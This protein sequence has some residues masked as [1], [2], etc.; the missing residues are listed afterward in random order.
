MGYGSILQGFPQEN[1]GVEATGSVDLPPGEYSIRTISDDAVR[2]WVDD[3]LVIDH[4]D[5]H[6]SRVDYAPLAPG[7]HNLRI[8]YL[9]VGGWTELRFEI[10]KGSNRSTGSA[11]PH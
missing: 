1:W 2:V 5:P 9:Q 3:Q 11:G 7:L 8:Q 10:I 6:E 4:W